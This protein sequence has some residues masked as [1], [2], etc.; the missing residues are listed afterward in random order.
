MILIAELSEQEKLDLSHRG[1]T[2]LPDISHLTSLRELHIEDNELQT[3][4]VL[5]AGL[6]LLNACNN[7]LQSLPD[8]SYLT[9]L[10]TLHIAYNKLQALPDI[11][12]MDSLRV[13]WA[14][15][16]ELQTLPDIPPSLTDL[17][18][19]HNKLQSLPDFSRM[20]DQRP[21][22]D[23][24]GSG[25]LRVLNVSYN[26]LQALPDFLFMFVLHINGNNLR[27]LPNIT[28]MD[29]IL[30]IFTID[31]NFTHSHIENVGNPLLCKEV[32]FNH[33]EADAIRRHIKLFKDK[34]T[35]YSL[36]PRDVIDIIQGY[37]SY[38]P[39]TLNNPRDELECFWPL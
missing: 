27:V 17:Y 18:V 34:S 13:L 30:N 10:Q 33:K 7:Q 5:P 29:D 36:L 14:C 28:H 24:D 16:N 38:V 37:V 22:C 11:S 26:N 12:H 25:G 21:A 6:R 31:G 4:P 2:S 39:I 15:Y 32:T 3:L 19:S 35:L 8:I 23:L 9:S 1:L 20:A